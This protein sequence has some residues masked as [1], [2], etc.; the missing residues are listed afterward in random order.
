MSNRL[1]I[2]AG[3][4]RRAHADA[5]EAVKTAAKRAIDAGNALMKAKGVAKHGEWLP[6][7]T[8]IGVHE[9]AVQQY[10]SFAA[11]DLKSYTV[12]DLAGTTPK[13]R[14]GL[15]RSHAKAFFDKSEVAAN[16]ESKQ[17]EGTHRAFGCCLRS[18]RANACDVSTCGSESGAKQANVIRLG[19]N[20]EY[21]KP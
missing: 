16:D 9:R 11:L 4:I 12:S 21:P 19:A 1:S 8:A 2:L 18:Y 17:L 6:F 10:M 15:I 3:G 7:L 20:G 14:F 5:Q 13:L